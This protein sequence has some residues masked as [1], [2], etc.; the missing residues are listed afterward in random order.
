MKKFRIF[1]LMGH[2]LVET[3]K[4]LHT[5][6]RIKYEKHYPLLIK[7]YDRSDLIKKVKKW[8]MKN[9]P[10]NSRVEALKKKDRPYYTGVAAEVLVGKTVF[11]I[12]S[13]TQTT[14]PHGLKNYIEIKW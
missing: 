3:N 2:Y 6:S 10:T 5:L 11:E 12:P 4:N 7:A 8:V 14:M 1:Y 13:T 9:C